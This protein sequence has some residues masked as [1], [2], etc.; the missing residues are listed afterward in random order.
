ML[1]I[2]SAAFHFY[3]LLLYPN[4]TYTLDVLAECFGGDA[5]DLPSTVFPL[6][7]RLID[8]AQQADHSL[9][10]QLSQPHTKLHRTAF[11]GGERSYN[12]ICHNDQIVIPQSLRRPVIEWY[13]QHLLHPGE[14]R[15]E[16]TIRQHFW[17]AN[18]REEIVTYV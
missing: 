11:Y 17:W 12:L 4:T 9:L 10:H 2:R 16:K 14:N 18:M 8:K 1:L 6:Q 15:T 3:K 13:H 5:C 7:Y